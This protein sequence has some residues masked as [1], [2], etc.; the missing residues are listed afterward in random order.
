MVESYKKFILVSL[1]IYGKTATISSNASSIVQRSM[2]SYC[3]HYFDFGAAFD[4]R[5]GD[6]LVALQKQHEDSFNKDNNMGLVKQCIA[7]LTRGNIE[8]LTDTYLTLSL[9]D[10]AEAGNLKSSEEGESVVLRMVFS[11]LILIG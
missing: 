4:K 9:S 11:L 3:Q 8:R 1:L 5:E 10:I 7:S 6:K 2:K